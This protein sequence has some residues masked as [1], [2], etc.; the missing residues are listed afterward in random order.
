M[1]HGF[2]PISNGAEEVVEMRL[3]LVVIE[4]TAG[5]FEFGAFCVALRFKDLSIWAR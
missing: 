5:F 4:F 3:A 1:S 2:E